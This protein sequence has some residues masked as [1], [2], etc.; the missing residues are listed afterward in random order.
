MTGALGFLP[1]TRSLQLVMAR[2]V[3]ELAH[4]FATI[5]H[6]DES[7]HYFQV[8]QTIVNA[9]CSHLSNRTED[10]GNSERDSITDEAWT[11]EVL[12]IRIK[13]CLGLSY[14]RKELNQCKKATSLIDE[15]QNLNK[16]L[17]DVTRTAT[18]S[19]LALA[20]ETF[21]FAMFSIRCR[22][23]DVAGARCAL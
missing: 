13:T 21:T 23:N 18:S 5:Q 16:K 14:L 17:A 7:I 9:P 11:R 20:D 4:H 19:P 12:L 22:E 15:A 3:L 6:N 8:I 2:H 1:Q 10:F